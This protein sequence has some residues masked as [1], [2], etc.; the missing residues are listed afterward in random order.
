MKFPFQVHALPLLI[1]LIKTLRLQAAQMKARPVRGLT[2]NGTEK[3]APHVFCKK[4]KWTKNLRTSVSENFGRISMNARVSFSTVVD[5]MRTR[6]PPLI[7]DPGLYNLDL[8]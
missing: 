6:R 3:N 1:K 2:R 8:L 4:T 5:Q 7:V